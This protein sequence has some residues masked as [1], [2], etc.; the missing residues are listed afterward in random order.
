MGRAEAVMKGECE[1]LRGFLR[2]A[3]MASLIISFLIFLAAFSRV[4][5]LFLLK[6]H[7]VPEFSPLPIALIGVFI[8][9]LG[10]SSLAWVYRTFPPLIMMCRTLT[11]L[12]ETLKAFAWL[13]LGSPKRQSELCREESRIIAV[14]PYSCVRHP[15]YASVLLT[16][17]GLSITAPWLSPSLLIAAPAYYILSMAEERVLDARSCGAYSKFMRDKPLLNP[18]RL[19]LCLLE[20]LIG[21]RAGSRAASLEANLSSSGGEG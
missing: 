21:R 10:L 2:A 7:G 16:L 6:E 5:W 14:G 3:V 11:D 15:L 1:G 8:A 19:A 12:P 13:L 18:F 20:V 17:I 9:V 4:I